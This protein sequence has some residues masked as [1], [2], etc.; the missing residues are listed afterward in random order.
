[1]YF[2]FDAVVSLVVTLEDG[3]TTEAAMVGN[4]GAIGMPS[5]MDGK[6]APST[7]ISTRWRHGSLRSKSIQS[8]RLPITSPDIDGDAP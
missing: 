4:D 8:C 6:L 7:A 5:A 2:P 3:Q 1:V